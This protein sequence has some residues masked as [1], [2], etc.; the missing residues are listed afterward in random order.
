[1]F[2]K[3]LVLAVWN[4]AVVQIITVL[5]SL[6]FEWPYWLTSL[7]IVLVVPLFSFLAGRYLVFK[8][9]TRARRLI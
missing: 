9:N 2:M 5:G 1:M 7:C 8:P 3:F 6:Y 4:L